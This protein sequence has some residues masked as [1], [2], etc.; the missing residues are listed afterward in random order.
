MNQKEAREMG[1]DEGYGIVEMNWDDLVDQSGHMSKQ[2]FIDHVIGKAAETEIE[3]RHTAQ[4]FNYSRYPD[5]MWEAYESGVV[6]GAKRAVRDLIKSRG[7]KPKRAKSS[8]C[9][10]L[11]TNM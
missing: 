8:Y 4:E 1:I 3:S 6:A 11:S 5:E 10:K 9:K 2:E 7:W